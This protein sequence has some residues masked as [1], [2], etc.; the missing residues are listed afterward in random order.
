MKLDMKISVNENRL[1]VSKDLNS[2]HILCKASSK[3]VS[4]TNYVQSVKCCKLDNDVKGT[5][6]VVMA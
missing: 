1:Y 5:A 3:V 2:S 4:V 6:R